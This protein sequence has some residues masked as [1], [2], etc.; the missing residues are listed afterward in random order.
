MSFIKLEKLIKNIVG[1]K[2]NAIRCTCEMLMFDFGQYSLHAQCLTRIIKDDDILLTT[3]DY[4]S[5]DGKNEKN[6]DEYYNLTKYKSEIE[7]G[8]V[9]AVEMNPL[10]DVIITLDNGVI[11]QIFIQNSYAHYD[12]ESEQYRFFETADN[13]TEDEKLPPHYVVYSKHIEIHS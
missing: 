4:Q 9:L 6:N 10:C 7:S 13:E 5:W 1:L 11:I 12:K 8:K 3:F 2:L